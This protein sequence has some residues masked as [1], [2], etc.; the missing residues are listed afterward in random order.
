MLASQSGLVLVQLLPGGG[1]GSIDHDSPPIYSV[2]LWRKSFS[3]LAILPA[4][5]TPVR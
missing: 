4:E 1:L 5:N 2:A 3:R